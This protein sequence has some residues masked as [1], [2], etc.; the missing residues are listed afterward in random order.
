MAL[1]NTPWT[2]SKEHL[3][4]ALRTPMP[5]I[6][7]QFYDRMVA[8]ERSYVEKGVRLALGLWVSE[9]EPELM[10][11]QGSPRPFGLTAKGHGTPYISIKWDP[12]F[13]LTGEPQRIYVGRT[14]RSS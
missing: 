7:D 9:L 12:N 3:E 2:I 6:K 11:R 10:F 4:A 5:S 8:A 1:Q 14:V 13:Y